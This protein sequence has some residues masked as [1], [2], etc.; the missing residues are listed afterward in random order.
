MRGTDCN[1]VTFR[2]AGNHKPTKRRM[3]VMFLKKLLDI[4]S[5]SIMGISKYKYGY[6]Y[7]KAKY[8]GDKKKGG[9]RINVYGISCT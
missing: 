4:K 9:G 7:F 1:R 3:F 6:D 2:V 8:F 5:S